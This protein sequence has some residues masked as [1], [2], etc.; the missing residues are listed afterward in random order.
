MPAVVKS[1]S[2]VAALLWA[3]CLIGCGAAGTSDTLAPESPQSN[4]GL[5][6]R[7]RELDAEVVIETTVKETEVVS[8]DLSLVQDVAAA[9]P[10]V[11]ALAQVDRLSLHSAKATP[12]DFRQLS[13]IRGLRFLDLSQT[14]LTDADLQVVE[15]LPDLEFLLLWNTSIG[16]KGLSSLA[17]LKRLRK[18]DLSSTRVTA[19]GLE[20]LY[21]LDRLEELLLENPK[22]RDED[23][24]A[25]RAQ[26]PKTL[27][28]H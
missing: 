28:V 26:L 24:Q 3:T 22:I 6:V 16:D 21:P 27:I 17:K 9:L 2:L 15:S 4:A 1:L 14:S 5:I 10:L 25:L 7:L 11:A 23:F 12:D 13:G 18:L 20:A 8:V 19:A